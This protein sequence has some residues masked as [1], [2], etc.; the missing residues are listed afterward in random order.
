M[1]SDMVVVPTA[2]V[3]LAGDLVVPARSRAVVLFAHG[4]GSSRHSP[5]NRM[6]AA[7]LRTA[8]LGTLL[9]DLLGEREERRDAL[10]AEHRFDIGLL[11][12]RL[13][14]AVDWLDTQPDTRGLP[15]VLFGA[16]T[17]AAA[18]LVA[19]VERPDRVLTVVSRGGRPDLAG[20]ALERVTVPV[21]LLVG[22]RDQD[23]LALNQEA[24][25][26]LSCPHALHV[27]PQATHLFEEPGALEHVAET[28][29]RWCDD[30]LWDAQESRTSARTAP[31][32]S[33]EET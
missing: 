21:L 1:I 7:E 6:V 3:T 9:M 15:V 32:R 12:R 17:G 8:G 23:V 13:V 11:G 22:G 28:A 18:A 30:R 20:D 26:R 10:T 25:R 29:G 33:R 16:S 31:A 4:S 14:A 5:R 24:A 27:V 2:D 19:A